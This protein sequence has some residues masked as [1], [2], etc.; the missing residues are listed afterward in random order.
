M[1]PFR[2]FMANA[3]YSHNPATETRE[4]GQKRC[5]R[6]LADAERR[7]RD[8]GC[9]YRWEVDP[10]VRSSD[11]IPDHE[12]GGKYRDPWITWQCVMYDAQGKAIGS[13]HGIDFGRNG[14]PFGSPYKRVVEAELALDSLTEKEGA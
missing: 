1:N 5:A 2:F 7:A 9:S 12:D 3:G 13:L 4:Q 8:A 11:W 10:E 14:S 6:L